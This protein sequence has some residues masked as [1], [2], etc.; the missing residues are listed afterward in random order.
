MAWGAESRDCER[1]PGRGPEDPGRRAAAVDAQAKKGG[2]S[3]DHLVVL[4]ADFKLIRSPAS[5]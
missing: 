3:E 2:S 1:S 5:A 4:L